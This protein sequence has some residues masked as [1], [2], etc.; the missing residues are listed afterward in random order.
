MRDFIH[1]DLPVEL[2]QKQVELLYKMMFFYFDNG[3][4]NAEHRALDAI[5]SIESIIKDIKNAK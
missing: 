1:S 2:L 4:R 3:N 5:E